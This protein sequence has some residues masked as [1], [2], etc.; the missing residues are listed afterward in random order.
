MKFSAGS[1]KSFQVP[2]IPLARKLCR[3]LWYQAAAS[4]RVKSIQLTLPYHI[5]DTTGC[6]PEVKS[7]EEEL[8][9]VHSGS[10][11]RSSGSMMFTRLIPNCSSHE[12]ITLGFGKFTGSQVNICRWFM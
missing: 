6:P 9:V 8:S 5:E 12:F 7:H 1:F 3:E 10:V 2:E 4:V 11:S